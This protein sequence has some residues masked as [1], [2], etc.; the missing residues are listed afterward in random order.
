MELFEFILKSLTFGKLSWNYFSDKI[1]I[2]I[3]VFKVGIKQ[4][5]HLSSLL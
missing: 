2:T 1:S 4:K 5:L 3:E